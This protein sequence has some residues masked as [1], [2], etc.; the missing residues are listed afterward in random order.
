MSCI[1]GRGKFP[2]FDHG[3]GDPVD[4]DIA[5]EPEH[6]VVLIEGNYVLLGARA[7]LIALALPK[8]HC[9][10]CTWHQ[11]RWQPQPHCW[12][13]RCRALEGHKGDSG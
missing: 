8:L 3:I 1:A 12:Q 13:H 9:P 4:D 10:G 5:V 7:P 2:S 11:S 6:R